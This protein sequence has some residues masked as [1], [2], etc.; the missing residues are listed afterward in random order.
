MINF[1]FS[2]PMFRHAQADGSRL[3]VSV[4]NHDVS[5]AQLAVLAQRTSAWL[6]QGPPRE[7]GFVAI[8]ASRSLEA[9]V[10]VLGT[11]WSGDAYVPINPK[12][13][14]DRIATLFEI[15]KPVALITDAGG[16]KALTGRALATAPAMILNSFDELPAHDPRDCP[17][18]M[19][20]EDRA[21]MIF[22]SGST[23]VPKGVMVPLRAIHALVAG[24]QE[25]YGFGPHDRFSKAYNLSF[26]G[27]IHDMFTCWNAGASLHPVPARQL[28]APAKFI[29]EKQLTMWTS[30]PST[31]VFLER[32]KLLQPGAFPSLRCTIFS[33]EPLPLRSALAWQKAAPNSVVDNIC[34]HTEACCFSTLER[35]SDPPNVTPKLGLVAIGKALPGFEAAVFDSDC[36]PLPPGREGELALSGPQVALGYFGDGERTAARFPSIGGKVWYRTGDLVVVDEIGSL[37]HL[38]RIDNQV[39]VLGH[40]IELGEVESHLAEIC[41]TDCVAAVAWPVEHGSARGI[42]AFH[43]AEGLSAKEIRDKMVLRVPRYVVPQVVRYLEKIPLTEQGKIDRA[44]L[45]AMLET[46]ADAEAEHQASP[47]A[48]G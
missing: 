34:G 20:S 39:K 13:P 12:L 19:E 35:L 24:M 33:G 2:E 3:A 17:R 16:R 27:S 48:I 32:M 1:N 44:A 21:Y 29:Q 8:L 7:R 31:A 43:C 38:G 26:D 5:Y 30:V 18:Q 41:G 25:V 36:R 14:E 4:D 28:M 47:L 9:Y 11:G 6:N 22:T 46:A 15:V 45:R 23:G 37:H 10:G 40:R 42:A